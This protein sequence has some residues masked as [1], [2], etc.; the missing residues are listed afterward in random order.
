[1]SA[2]LTCYLFAIAKFLFVTDR[3]VATVV[4]ETA[5]LFLSQLKKLLK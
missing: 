2:Q 1:L 4:M 5:Q 3:Q